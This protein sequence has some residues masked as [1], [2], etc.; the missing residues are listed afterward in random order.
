MS[1]QGSNEWTSGSK[2]KVG[3]LILSE[4]LTLEG[5]NVLR[6]DV[7]HRE[8]S[9]AAHGSYITL[10][11]PDF[12]LHSSSWESWGRGDVKDVLVSIVYFPTEI[13]HFLRANAGVL[14]LS[15]VHL[16][17]HRDLH[18]GVEM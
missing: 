18:E 12:H 8:T 3:K 2:T 15:E 10:S 7:G 17:G 1:D 4:R 6:R 14:C 9:Q 11:P 5:M 13:R 16:S